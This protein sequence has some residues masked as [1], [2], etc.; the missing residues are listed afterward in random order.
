M[1]SSVFFWLGLALLVFWAMGAYNRLVRLRSQ[2]LLAFGLLEGLFRQHIG[3]V[4]VNLPVE[5]AASANTEVQ[6]ADLAQASEKFSTALK[7]ARNQP[8]DGALIEALKQTYEALL[9][10]QRHLDAHAWDAGQGG[11]ER[12]RIQCEQLQTQIELAKADFNRQVDAYNEA[13]SEFPA[14]LLVWLIGFKPA[15]CL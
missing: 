3:L 13:I 5:V 10:S 4:T 6:S 12:W 9:L 8:L 2:G 14:I 7:K 1:N 11:I 15:R